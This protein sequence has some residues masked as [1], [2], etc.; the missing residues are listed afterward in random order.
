MSALLLF[1]MGAVGLLPLSALGTG[2]N[3]GGRRDGSQRPDRRG[4]GGPGD[5]HLDSARGPALR[6]GPTWGVGGG[7]LTEQLP[8]AAEQAEVLALPVRTAADS[9]PELDL[10]A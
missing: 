8:G 7:R 3:R 10:A 5:R 6:R 2:P 1:S 9:E 4:G